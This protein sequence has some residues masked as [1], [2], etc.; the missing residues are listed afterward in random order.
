MKCCKVS[1][2]FFFWNK[3]KLVQEEKVG[4]AP[5]RTMSVNLFGLICGLRNRYVVRN[6]PISN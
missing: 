5:T 6:P 3:K 1:G 4:R 2:D